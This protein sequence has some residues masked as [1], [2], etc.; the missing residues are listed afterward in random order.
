MSFSTQF[1]PNEMAYWQD[2]SASYQSDDVKR[3]IF[4][5][6]TDLA[7]FSMLISPAAQGHLETMAQRA[8]QLTVQRF[9]KVM[10]LFIP[11]YLSNECSNNCTYCG[12]SVANKFPRRTLN[13]DEIRAEGILLASKGFR[14]LL[15]L[16]GEAQRK[17]GTEYIANAV[18]IL[19]PYFSSIGIEVQPMEEI[20]YHHLIGAGTDSLTV[21]QE[22]YHPDSYSKYHLSGK[23]K[24][25]G[26]RLDTPD[27]GGKAGFPKMNIG[28]L[29]GLYDWRYEALSIASHLM[30]LNR[31][32]WKSKLGISFP[33][34]TKVFQDFSPKY[35]ISDAEVTQFI[36]AFRLMFPDI[37]IS[38]ST[39]ERAE[40]R[41][42][43]LPLGITQM[44]AESMTS[45]GGYSGFDEEAQFETTD[46][47][48]LATIQ[49]HLTAVGYEPVFKDW[50]ATL[51]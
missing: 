16:T 47:R 13:A 41:D 21:Y 28:A 24:E 7:R 20:D 46:H 39:R 15:V 23:K 36:L 34:I 32:Y 8:H 19:A 43:L 45:P 14:H 35:L 10:Q 11:M 40:F 18:Q 48:P 3:A 9:G 50:D 33:R 1:D 5:T 30:Y 25:F 51:R 22:T 26:Y 17:V 4:A 49:S 31:H 44:S 29:L 42:H 27:R 6:G 12:F 2:R 37:G 38:L